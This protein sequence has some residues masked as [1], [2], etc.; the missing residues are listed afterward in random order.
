MD[1]EGRLEWGWGMV[2]WG[3][4]YGVFERGVKGRGEVEEKGD[5][6]DGEGGTGKGERSKKGNVPRRLRRR[7][8]L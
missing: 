5:K 1:G 3:Y 4:R 2:R 8:H 6:G 7:I